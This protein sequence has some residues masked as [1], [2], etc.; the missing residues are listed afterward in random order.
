MSIFPL[1]FRLCFLLF[2]SRKKFLVSLTQLLLSLL[3]L[4]SHLPF[5]VMG[6]SVASGSGNVSFLAK[7]FEAKQHQNDLPLFFLIYPTQKHN[8]IKSQ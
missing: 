7:T 3:F 8:K 1:S 6:W 2:F 4:V 5:S